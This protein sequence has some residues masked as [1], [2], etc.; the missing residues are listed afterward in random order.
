MKNNLFCVVIIVFLSIGC[1][2]SAE[3]KES[4]NKKIN[5]CIDQ[6]LN[7]GWDTSR[8]ESFCDNHYY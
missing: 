4:I 7:E 3:K 6:K 8:A 5:N 1:T 2:K